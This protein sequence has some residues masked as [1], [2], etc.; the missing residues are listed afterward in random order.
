MTQMTVRRIAKGR[1]LSNPT[2]TVKV[3]PLQISDMPFT[4]RS[5]RVCDQAT[6]PW[7]VMWKR[8]CLV[9]ACQTLSIMI[10]LRV[11]VSI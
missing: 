4:R 7:F 5:S 10:L 1:Y 11:T 9:W 6:T 3:C 2:R 8:K